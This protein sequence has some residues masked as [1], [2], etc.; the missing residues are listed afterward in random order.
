MTIRKGEDWGTTAHLGQDAPVVS[1]DR[2]LANLFRVENGRLHGPD[3]VGIIGGDLARTVGAT[4]TAAELRRGERV[5]LPIDLGTIRIDDRE[6]VMAANCVIRRTRWW[7]EIIGVMNASF[8][9]SWNTTPSGHPNDGRFDVVT[10]KLTAA[11][12]WKARSRLQNGT[13]VPHPDITIRRLKAGQFTP[14]AR[15]RVWIDGHCVGSAHRVEFTV[16][17]DAVYLII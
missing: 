5:A 4:A 3:Q 16:W 8:L 1:S 11:D 2:D 6:F 12:R 10:A 9:G 13:H 14:D 7:G 15:A 17:P